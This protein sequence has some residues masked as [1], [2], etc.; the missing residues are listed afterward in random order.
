MLFVNACKPETTSELWQS[1]I[2]QGEQN[3]SFNLV[4]LLHDYGYRALPPNKIDI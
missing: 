1:R 3:I 4:D 2:N